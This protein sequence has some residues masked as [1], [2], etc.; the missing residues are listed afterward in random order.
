MTQCHSNN[1]DVD[2]VGHSV[3]SPSTGERWLNCTGSIFLPVSR[4]EVSAAAVEG[5]ELHKLVH[6]HII[7]SG[8][9]IDGLRECLI[10]A[11][12]I[13]E[14]RIFK[15]FDEIGID[16]TIDACVEDSSLLADP[17]TNLLYD[18]ILYVE[19]LELD[20]IHVEKQVDISY[21]AAGCFGTPDIYGYKGTEL[22]IIDLKTGI[23]KQVAAKENIQLYLYS[24][25]TRRPDTTKVVLHIVQPSYT[26]KT[27]CKTWEVT[28]EFEQTMDDLL[29]SFRLDYVQGKGTFKLGAWC[30]YCK[31]M[32]SCPL[33]QTMLNDA[34][35]LIGVKRYDQSITELED[36]FEKS[37]LLKEFSK[38]A[39]QVLLEKFKDGEHGVKTYLLQ[40]R[41]SRKL[42]KVSLAMYLQENDINWQDC[43]SIDNVTVTALKKMKVPDQVIDNLST[44]EIVF[45]VQLK[46][47]YCDN[48]YKRA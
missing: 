33:Y 8:L 30:K 48:P 4:E 41:S 1:S 21:V 26:N 16:E 18:Y 34:T 15:M 6:D 40:K 43:L 10:E 31:S 39:E 44:T 28:N 22:H 14:N 19:S 11:G 47:M 29:R 25:G 7:K 27:V 35:S 46:T 45:E 12:A 36:I 9:T 17:T 5:R 13:D 24:L 3:L 23:G 20:E 37:R 32:L 38:Y 42:N 2:E